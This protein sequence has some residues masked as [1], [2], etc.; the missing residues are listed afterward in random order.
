MCFGRWVGPRLRNRNKP[1]SANVEGVVNDMNFS[2]DNLVALGD[3][4]GDVCG[5]DGC[6]VPT[7]DAEDK[8]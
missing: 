2:L 4:T 6:A 3:D 5:P 8:D 7:F 1:A